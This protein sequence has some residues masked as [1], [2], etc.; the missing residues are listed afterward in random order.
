MHPEAAIY[1]LDDIVAAHERVEAGANAKVL[2][3]L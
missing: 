3:R 2:I 1:A